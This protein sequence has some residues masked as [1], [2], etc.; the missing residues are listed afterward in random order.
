MLSWRTTGRA[1]I[2]DVRR[3]GTM[4]RITWHEAEQLFVV[5][6]WQ[7]NVCTAATRVD[8]RDAGAMAGV[9]VDGL[10]GA[11]NAPV[12]APSPPPPGLLDRVLGRLGV[13][14]A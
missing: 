10:S 12:P 3:N 13:R 6:H 11:V 9:I 7:D 4:L 8:V 2:E 5:S 14:A 1:M